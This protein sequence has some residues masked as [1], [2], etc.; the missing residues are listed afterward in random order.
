MRIVLGMMVAMV[1]GTSAAACA[2]TSCLE[3]DC[4][5]GRV[6][7]DD[8]ADGAPG[9]GAEDEVPKLPACT[10]VGKPHLGLGGVDVAARPNEDVPAGDRARMKPFS[11]LVTDYRR[12]L[13]AENVPASLNGAAS[14]FGVASE[15]WFL[16]PIAS[17][18]Y[19]NAA[20]DVGFEG[21]NNL[22]KK[23]ARFATMPTKDTARAA[24]EEWTR[25]FWSRAATPEQLDACVAVALE[26]T[27]ETVPP[28]RWAYACASVLA[29]TG[30]LTF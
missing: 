14:T 22:T 6:G 20:F 21:C 5:R 26:T 29:A 3:G 8:E 15:R 4:R 7:A 1:L 12:V 28:R 2:E 16:E 24:C 23:D 17:A 27:S 19:V 10:T 9:G 25:K 30:F 11:A 13:G 18:V